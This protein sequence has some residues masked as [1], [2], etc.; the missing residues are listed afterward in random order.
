MATLTMAHREL[1]RRAP[2]ER[3]PSLDG[4]LDFCREQQRESRDL[5]KPPGQL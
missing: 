3:F 2:D 1:Y 5:W 4:L